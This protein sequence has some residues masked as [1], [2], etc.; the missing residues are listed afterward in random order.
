MKND[1]QEQ[2]ALWDLLGRSRQVR[3]TPFFAR[4]VLRQIRHTPRSPRLPALVLR[5]LP[6]TTLALLVVGFS[7]SLTHPPPPPPTPRRPPANAPHQAPP[8]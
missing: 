7:L 3:P 5:W 8:P 4:N 6:A 1:L 2:D